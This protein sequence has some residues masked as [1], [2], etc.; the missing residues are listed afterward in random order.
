MMLLVFA[1]PHVSKI[2]SAMLF[3][4]AALALASSLILFLVE[5]NERKRG[6]S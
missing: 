1:M 5:V 2:V 6:R 3:D 4:I